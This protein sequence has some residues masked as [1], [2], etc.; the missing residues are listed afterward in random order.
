MKKGVSLVIL[1]IICLNIYAQRTL[2]S[3]SLNKRS[4]NLAAGLSAIL[5]GL[6]QAYNKKYWKIPVIYAGLGTLTYLTYRNHNYYM[7]FQNAYKNLA[8]TNPNGLYYM[9]NT[10]FTLQGLEA[11]KN[12]YRRYR[13]MYAIF[14]V[15][16]YILNIIDAAVDAYLFDFDVSDDLSLH[17][18]PN[19]FKETNNPVVY[20]GLSFTLN[21]K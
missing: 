17:I 16:F 18:M 1:V 2:D 5:P 8:E 13:D 3:L 12:Y 21:V 11:G 20:T 4:P 19:F 14:T 10:S 6:G 7:D 9:Y 15:G